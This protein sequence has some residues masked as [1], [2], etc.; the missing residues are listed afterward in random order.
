MGLGLLVGREG[1]WVVEF[2]APRGRGKG[3]GELAWLSWAA[4]MGSRLRAETG[5][6]RVS[7]PSGQIERR[8]D[9][10]FPKSFSIFFNTNS[11]MI[12]IK[13]KYSFK[14]TFQDENFWEVS[15]TELLQ[16]FE[17]SF[18]FQFSFSFLFFSEPF[19]NLFSKAI[20]IYFEFWIQSL[21]AI[22]QMHCHVC[23]PIL[24]LLMINFN[25]MK[26]ILFPIFHVHKNS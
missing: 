11:N 8:E 12:Q 1:E 6:E 7:G 13:F 18:I 24:L 5:R 4:V 21:I 25:I 17:N 3:S 14:Y 20:W 19:S 16:T 15:K 26:N 9:F 10:S 2:A 23:T 22:N